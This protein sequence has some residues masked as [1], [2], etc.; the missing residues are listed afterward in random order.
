M[1]KMLENTP[2]EGKRVIVRVDYNVPIKDGKILDD[3]KIRASLPTINYL[4]SKKCSIILLS[5][6]GKVKTEEDAIKNTLE[7]VALHLQELLQRKILFSKQ[8]RSFFLEETARNLKPGDI[9]MLENTRIEDINGKRESGN[10]PQL[11]SYWASL[12]EVFVMDAFGSAHRKHAST[13]G[14]NKYLPSCIGLLVQKELEMLDKFVL[15]PTHPFTV[16]M[17]GAKIDDKLSLIKKLLPKC[18]HLLLTGGLANT[19]LKVLNI[20]IG[21]SIASDDE[22][23]LNDVN[24]LLKQYKNKIMLPLDVIVGNSYNSNYV[25]EKTLLEIKEDDRIQDIGYNTLQK[26][27][28]AIDDAKTIFVNGTAGM[29]EETKYA[30]GTKEMF[31]MLS[32]STANVVIGG[33]DSVSAAI[34]FGYKDKF[35]YL[36]TGGGATLEYICDGKLDA[37]EELK[38]GEESEVLDL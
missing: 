22:N 28:L 31:R 25:E 11:A 24:S 12:G 35:T 17:G 19:C 14:I 20:P 27:K 13:S 18:E 26:Y 6:L 7:P 10:D 29:Y 30:N 15:Y 23:I 9:L 33:G 1:Y 38:E 8:T 3:N 32:E 21:E 34:N 4:L 16:V 37:L 2:V 36:S 5:H